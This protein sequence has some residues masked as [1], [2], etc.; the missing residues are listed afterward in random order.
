MC[1]N[2]DALSYAR[3][4]YAGNGLTLGADEDHQRLIDLVC[5]LRDEDLPDAIEYLE[6]LIAGRTPTKC[7][8]QP[9]RR[10]RD[11]EPE[12]EYRR[13]HSEIQAK[14]FRLMREAWAACG[15]REDALAWVRLK[16]ENDP[17]LRPLREEIE[18]FLDGT[19]PA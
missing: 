16:L 14:Y 5:R 13:L 10:L 6:W 15:D 4:Q 3:D 8:R 17:E 7:R 11:E 2:G 12:P 19:P 1:R 9:D 18:R